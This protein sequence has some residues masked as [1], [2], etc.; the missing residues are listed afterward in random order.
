MNRRLKILRI[1]YNL[2]L[3]SHEAPVEGKWMINVK[4]QHGSHFFEREIRTYWRARERKLQGTEH[5][6]FLK[7]HKELISIPYMLS[8]IH[9]IH[10]FIKIIGFTNKRT[11]KIN[12]SL[13][14]IQSLKCQAYSSKQSM[15]LNIHY[16]PSKHPPVSNPLSK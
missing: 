8:H 10:Y 2:L 3:K 16:T 9:I 5:I 1:T 4:V 13:K 15:S 7:H 12:C 11:S 14:K 6:L